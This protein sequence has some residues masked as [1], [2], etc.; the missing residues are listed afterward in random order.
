VVVS[1]IC[2]YN[3]LANSPF[4]SLVFGINNLRSDEMPYFGAKCSCSAAVVQLLCGQNFNDLSRPSR[5]L[6][7]E[8][9]TDLASES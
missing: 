2:P 4:H 8:R 3:G 7:M 9:L 6:T 1:T 5:A